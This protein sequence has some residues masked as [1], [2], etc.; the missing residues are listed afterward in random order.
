LRIAVRASALLALTLLIPASGSLA[1]DGSDAVKGREFAHEVC[2]QCHA[3]ERDTD[4]SP[5]LPA[6]TFEEIANVPGM[7]GTALTVI[8]R[9][10]HREMPDLILEEEDLRDVIAYILSLRSRD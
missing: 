1:Q 6:P 7:T 4:Y 5:Y 3:V 9:N 2:A 8:L 10:P